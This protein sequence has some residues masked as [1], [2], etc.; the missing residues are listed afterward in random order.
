MQ[1][2]NERIEPALEDARYYIMEKLCGNPAVAQQDCQSIHKST[3][4]FNYHVHLRAVAAELTC[5][6]ANGTC[7]WSAGQ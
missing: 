6:D 5:I 2:L 4:K 3:Y 7:S 1:N